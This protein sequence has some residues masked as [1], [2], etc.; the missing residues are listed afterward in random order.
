MRAVDCELVPVVVDA[1]LAVLENPTDSHNNGGIVE[2][3]LVVN[4]S[5][6]L[7]VVLNC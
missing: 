5:M 4:P 2:R 7:A 1:Y 6:R 3:S